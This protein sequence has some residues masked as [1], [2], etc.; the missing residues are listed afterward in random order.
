MANSIKKNVV[1]STVLTTANY[2]FPLIVYPYISRVLGVTNIG[3]CNFVDSII[4]YY[5]LFSMM[6]VGTFAIREVARNKDNKNELS[7]TF[8]SILKL[9]TISTFIVLIILLASIFCIPKFYEYKQLMFIGA[10]KVLS[11]YL[12]IEWFYKGIENFK[13][14]T[15]RTIV[16]KCFWVVSIFIFV[17]KPE[18]YNIYYLLTTLVITVNALVNTI[19]SKRFVTCS[20][21]NANSKQY[22]KPFLIMG[23]YALLTSMYTTFN[24]AYLGFEAGEKEVGFYTTAT[25]IHGIIL[26][27]FTAFT[28]VMLPRMSSL[29][30]QCK[31]E[32]FNI[33]FRKSV[34]IL[35]VF[36]FPIICVLAIFSDQLVFWISGAGYEKAIP[37]LQ[38]ITPLIFIIGYEQVLIIQIL[39][40]LKKENNVLT[41]SIIGATIGL[42]ANLL[43]VRHFMCI[44]SSVVWLLS[45]VAVLISA[46]YF[47]SKSTNLRFPI[48]ELLKYIVV[49]MPLLV[50]LLAIHQ[51]NIIGNFTIIIATI[52]TLIY[53]TI[54]EIYLFKNQIVIGLIQTFAKRINK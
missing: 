24:I 5:I 47:V 20:F 48:K 53:F 15:N 35:F 4:N 26:A 44:G 42:I 12:L 8:S 39:M 2:I 40:P 9:N 51:Y 11:N 54:V 17:R 13:Y 36:A 50:I 19:Y 21:K 22:L 7:K 45:E 28:G 37:C 46:Q 32:E 31:I 29:V 10:F 41:N 52:L 25:K 30:G 23:I 33:L 49:S 34:N 16:I 27:M 18:D 3:I 1:Y 43:L 38:I 6:G 14:I